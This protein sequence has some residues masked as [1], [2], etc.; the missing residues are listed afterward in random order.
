M[1]QE[2]LTISPTIEQPEIILPPTDLIYDDGEP[3]ESNRHRT[4]NILIDSVNQ[5]L[6]DREDEYF[7]YYSSHQVKN[8]DFKGP[9]FFVV[10]DTDGQKSRKAWVTLMSLWNYV[11]STARIDL[12]EKKR[13]YERVF[14]TT[15]YFVYNPLI[16]VLY[17]DGN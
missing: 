13:L 5:A 9:D 7:I 10:L 4:M 2:T 12:N 16:L 11:S 15:N 17:K 8:Q 3:M 1:S 14:K 6:I